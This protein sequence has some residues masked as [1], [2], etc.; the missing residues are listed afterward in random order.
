ADLPLSEWRTGTARVDVTRLDAAAGDLPITL[1]EPAHARLQGETVHVDR[2][3]VNAGPTRLSASGDVALMNGS[4]NLSLTATGDIGEAARAVEALRLAE[5]PITE[6]SGPLAARARVTGT[7]DEPVV[8]AD[9]NAGPGSV[10]IKDLS[11]VTDVR[12]QAHLEHDTI[13]LREAHALYEGAT[14]NATGSIP[15][16]LVR[17]TPAAPASM[18]ASLH[19]TAT[20]I[21]PA[22]LRGI[23]D[24]ATLED[25]AATIDV[26]V[27]VE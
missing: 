8:V 12:V 13:D 17:S 22:V 2:L 21:T 6:A 1:A 19:A 23:L 15:L 7:L 27:N 11:T 14:L 18:P 3:E 20:G 26:A 9:V 16:A 10:A 25:L 24:P 5:L 4:S